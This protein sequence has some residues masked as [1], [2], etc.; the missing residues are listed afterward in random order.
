MT[1]PSESVLLG[2]RQKMISET[3]Q[4]LGVSCPLRATAAKEEKHL[5]QGC[6]FFDAEW[7]REALEIKLIA[8]GMTSVKRVT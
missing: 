8:D 5:F 1:D 3:D 6:K 4:A 2:D 7:L